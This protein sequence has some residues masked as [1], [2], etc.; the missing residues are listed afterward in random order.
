MSLLQDTNRPVAVVRGQE[1]DEQDGE[2]V[3]CQ[4][5]DEGP[6]R[7]LPTVLEGGKWK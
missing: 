5:G 6:A 3:H 4:K 2:E 7:D 1:A